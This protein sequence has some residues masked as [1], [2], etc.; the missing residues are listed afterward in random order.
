NQERK[1]HHAG[2]RGDCPRAEREL[3]FRDVALY[4]N[5][6]ITALTERPEKKKR[7]RPCEPFK[8]T[9]QQLVVYYGRLAALTATQRQTLRKAL[10]ERLRKLA[11][12]PHA[13]TL[14][15]IGVVSAKVLKRHAVAT[16]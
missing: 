8:K 2:R 11:E 15:R 12:K 16:F 3:G 7:G 13:P 5:K 14:G 4:V 1:V 10:E 9:D 6:A